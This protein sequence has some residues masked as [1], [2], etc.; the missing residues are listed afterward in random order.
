MANTRKQMEREL[1][2][3]QLDRYAREIRQDL[4]R[5]KIS[6]ETVYNYVKDELD[7]KQCAVSLSTMKNMLCKKRGTYNVIT[8]LKVISTIRKNE[9]LKQSIKAVDDYDRAVI[10]REKERE[11]ELIELLSDDET[12]YGRD[13][14]KMEK[15]IHKMLGIRPDIKKKAVAYKL[16]SLE[17]LV[18]I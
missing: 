16:K 6:Y 17:I 3:V 1:Y 9:L 4:R 15:I 10:E 14:T 8:R 13:Y 5:C 18:S 2:N 12:W 11:L 7:E